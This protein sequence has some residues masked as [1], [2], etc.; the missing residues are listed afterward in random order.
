ML[1]LIAYCYQPP[2]FVHLAVKVLRFREFHDA[3]ICCVAGV[4]DPFGTQLLHM[5]VFNNSYWHYCLTQQLNSLLLGISS[6]EYV[7]DILS[8]SFRLK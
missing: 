8:A 1:F 3:N 4:G 2:F 6:H 7:K 5:F